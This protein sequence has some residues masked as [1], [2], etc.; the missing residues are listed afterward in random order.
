[1][2]RGWLLLIWKSQ[3]WYITR[4]QFWHKKHYKIGSSAQPFDDLNKISKLPIY[5]QTSHPYQECDLA[6]TFKAFHLCF[7]L[8]DWAFIP[9]LEASS[10]RHG[11]AEKY[12]NRGTSGWQ[13]YFPLL[14][15]PY[16]L[17]T[18]WV[19]VSTTNSI[20]INCPFSE[21]KHNLIPRGRPHTTL[22]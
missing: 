19:E 6:A 20:F 3:I 22:G 18:E 15:P 1:M 17:I 12:V 7:L 11:H 9:L 21:L 10:D 13:L 8:S 16:F 14:T 4:E 2:K 5:T